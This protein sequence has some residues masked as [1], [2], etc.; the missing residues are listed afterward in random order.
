VV[1]GINARNY[2]NR[3]RNAQVGDC[4][5]KINYTETTLSRAR[6]GFSSEHPGGAQFALADGSVRFISE[7]IDAD[8]GP[9]QYS[10][11]NAAN[12]TYER[13]CARG[14]LNPVGDF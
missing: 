12:S 6:R 9:D 14:D 2:G 7:T 10:T 3:G 4:G 13:L 5:P 11:N 8:M 1:F